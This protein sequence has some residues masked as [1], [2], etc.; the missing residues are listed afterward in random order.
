M[1]LSRIVAATA[2]ALTLATV[3][4]AGNASALDDVDF[5][6]E[7]SCEKDGGYIDFAILI[8][9][10]DEADR[11][12]VEL[13]GVV[14]DTDLPEGEHQFLGNGAFGDGMVQMLVKTDPGGQ[15]VL[16]WQFPVTCDGPIVEIE[17][18]CNDDG[19]GQFA[20]VG[21]WDTDTQT[22]DIFVN[23]LQV[24]D[25]EE[26]NAI[27]GY[28]GYGSFPFGDLLVEVYWNEGGGNE[29]Y[30]SATVSDD[31]TDDDSGAGI[32]DAGSDT[33]PLLVGATVLTLGGVALLG[34]RR[35]RRA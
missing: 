18:Q 20:M 6:Y 31:C 26:S 32:P 29:P 2:A 13:D 11:F 30:V 22:F 5:E 15:V 1:R 17:A 8:D 28:L 35:L 4:L 27:A 12:S 14:L 19:D 33:T 9:A 3:G 10:D 21:M 7:V 16:G 25:D 24:A 23:G 34:T